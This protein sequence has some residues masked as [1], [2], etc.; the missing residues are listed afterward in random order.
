MKQTTHNDHADSIDGEDSFGCIT[1][2]IVI[3]LIVIILSL[4]L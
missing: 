3:V 1:A 4:W 2:M